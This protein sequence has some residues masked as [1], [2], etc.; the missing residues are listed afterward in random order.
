MYHAEWHAKREKCLF[1][2]RTCP[3]THKNFLKS[4]KKN[5][6]AAQQLAVIKKYF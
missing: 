1:F 2:I 6:K 5:S 4:K 3:E